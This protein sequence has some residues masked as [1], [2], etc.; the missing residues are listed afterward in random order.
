VIVDHADRLHERVTD[1]R[2]DEPEAA[3]AQV[4]AQGSRDIRLGGDVTERRP[5][6]LD[7]RSPDE[8][9]DIP[10][11]GAVLPLDR[12]TGAGVGDGGLDLA[13]VSHDAV[14]GQQTA[15]IRRREA[16]SSLAKWLTWPSRFWSVGPGISQVV[17]DGGLRSAQ[18][19]EARAVYDAS[20]AAYRQTVLTAFKEVEDNLAA[21]RILAEEARVQDEAVAAARQTLAV[22]TNQYRAGTVSY[23]EVAVAQA[24]ALA[25]ERTAVDLRGRRMVAT[26]L[27]IKALGGGWTAEPSSAGR[28]DAR[29][30]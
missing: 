24:V 30:R 27:L 4:T 26:A 25:N 8:S 5:G 21:L 6:V 29:D 7:R 10:V 18:T 12:A 22:V 17:Y 23:L 28:V 20:V 11:E 3:P 19:D 13:A 16:G 2:A 15:D 9:P 1:D 14:I